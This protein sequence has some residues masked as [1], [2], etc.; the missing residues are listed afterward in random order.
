[1]ILHRRPCR[2][3]RPGARARARRRARAKA[4]AQLLADV[5]GLRAPTEPDWARSNW[6]SYC[7]GLPRHFDQQ[8]VMQALLDRGV[9]T[10]RGIMNS[11][12]EAA[13]AEPGSFR[14]QG[15]LANSVAAQNGSIILPLFA[16]MTEADVSFVVDAMREV[17]VAAEPELQ[18]A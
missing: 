18:P 5:P 1:M 9:A 16:Q 13:Y 8:W 14:A 6:Q 12:L 3:A 11:H 2:G 17:V 4:Y 10:R 15:G 7:V